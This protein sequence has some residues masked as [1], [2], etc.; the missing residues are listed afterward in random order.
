M[1][2]W[3]LGQAANPGCSTSSPGLHLKSHA[4]LAVPD[5]ELTSISKVFSH[6]TDVGTEVPR[7]FPGVS[8][9]A[10]CRAGTV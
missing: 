5:R 3:L 10:G 4:F 8:W 6:F 7:P 2:S 9:L 1:T